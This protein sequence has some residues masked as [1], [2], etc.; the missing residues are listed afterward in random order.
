MRY[1]H[2]GDIYGNANI[3]LDFSVNTNPLGLPI[4]VKQA[5]AERV[6]EFSQYPDPNC[7]LLRRAIVLDEGVS[8]KQILCGNGAADLIYRLCNAI[9][10]RKALVCA[11]T[12]SEYERALTQTGCTV[13]HHMLKESD[14]FAL[15]DSIL[16]KI[17]P[18][19]DMLFLCQPNN[20]TGRLIMPELLLEILYRADAVGA[21]TVVD[22]CF[23]G[24]MQAESCKALLPKHDKLIIIKAF[25]KMYAMAGLR[26]GYLLCADKALLLR[27]SDA[28]ACWSVSIPAQIAGEAALKVPNWREDTLR[29]IADEREFLSKELERLGI[30]VYPS[31][32]N[33]LLIKSEKPLYDALLSKGILIR[34]C[35]N[36]EGLD[37]SFF[38][39]AIK[40]HDE[41]ICLVKAMG[42]T[43]YG[44]NG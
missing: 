38:R 12:F 39:V 19:V 27:I 42:E 3:H 8:E 36:F 44:K 20:P 11:P 25:T 40:K 13:V 34:A 1:E 2:G 10:P 17:T 35:G 7:R 22:E 32:T 4:E 31:D 14:G 28:G 29:I 43:I 23:L 6:D 18:D 37:K 24:F 30:T 41:N 16:E 9:R 21:V 15:T 26:L 33:F 5:L